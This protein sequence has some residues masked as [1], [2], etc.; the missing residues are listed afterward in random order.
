[1]NRLVSIMPSRSLKSSLV[2]FRANTSALERPD[3]FPRAWGAAIPYRNGM[4]AAVA[5]SA[6]RYPRAVAVAT[7]DHS[8]TY[9]QLWRGS[10]A[11]ARGLAESGL[12]SRDRAGILC[13]NSP[14]FVYALL[15]VTK[16]GADI[17]LLNTATGPVQLADVIASENLTAVLHDDDFSAAILANSGMRAFDATQMQRIIDTRSRSWFAPPRRESRLVILTSGTTGRPKG[18]TRSA[19]NSSAENVAALVAAIPFRLRDTT[20]IAAPF[21]HGWGLVNLLVGLGLAA[22]VLTAP[23]FDSAHTLSLV[24]EHRARGLVVVPTMLQRICELPRTD[25]AR[26]DTDNLHIISSSGSALPGQLVTEVLNRFGPVLYNAYG[27]TEAAVVT[28]AGPADLY[29]A[30]TTAGQ[31]ALG[32]RVELLDEAGAPVTTPT[33]VGRIFVASSAR[34]EGYTNGQNKEVLNGL[35]STGDLGYFD[36]HGRLFVVGREDDMIVSGGENVYPSEIEELL[37]SD[38]RIAESAVIGV[39]DDRFG[40][41]LKAVIVVAPNQ[42]VGEQELKELI[43]HRLAKFKVPRVFEFVDA[44]PRNATGKIIRRQLK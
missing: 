4:L 5:A 42:H 21:F 38:V 20:V 34:F 19:S 28:I 6:A 26:A 37:N 22:T 14:I 8:V 30:P 44:L 24:A 39:D 17:V 29:R 9:S 43:A 18:A 36:A 2:L 7:V 33:T 11:L 3:R 35:M 27:S 32:V 13:R 25:L 1:M 41:A 12:G 23:E 10:S 16:L 31:R 15:A 40:K